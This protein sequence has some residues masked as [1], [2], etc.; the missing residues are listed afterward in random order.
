MG[1]NVLATGHD[2]Q[3]ITASIQHVVIPHPTDKGRR[4]ILVDMPG[5]DDTYISDEEIL[6]HI[7]LWL[8][9]S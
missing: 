9:R 4:I 6:T 7:A 2:L 3:S 5:F 1:E 8:A